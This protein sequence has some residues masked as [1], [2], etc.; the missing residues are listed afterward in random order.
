MH[1]KKF[2]LFLLLISYGFSEDLA[3]LLNE[4]RIESELSKITK[5]ESAG[6]VDI[7][8]RED[9]EKMQARSLLDILKTL[10]V[11]MLTRTSNN[12]YL[13]SK[14]TSSYI[15]MPAIRLFINDHDVTSTSFGS[16]MVVWSDMPVEYIDHIEVYKTAS[17]MEFSNEP[18]TAIIKVYTKKAEREEGG[19][20]RVLK[21]QKG[22]FEADTYFAHT[23][24]DGFSYFFYV[25]TNNI[26]R[27]KYD[28]KE[29]EISSDKKGYNF[30][31]DILYNDW[32]IEL[33][34]YFKENENFMGI[35]TN[36]TPSD[37]KVDVKQSYVHITKNF[38][39]SFKLQLEYD[40]LDYDR[41]YQ[42]ENGI[43]AGSAGIVD[44]YSTH[45]KDDVF[46]VIAEKRLLFEKN[47]LLL[48]AFYKYKG[49]KA[50]GKFD[51]ISTN[52]AN[53]L[54]LYSL[55]AENSFSFDEKTMIVGSIKEDFYIYDKEVRSHSHHIIR[56]GFIKNI[57]N[58]QFKA[59][60]TRT[61]YPVEFYKLYNKDD[62]PYKIN[63]NL[64]FPIIDIH[65]ASIRYKKKG[66]EVEFRASAHRL[67]D[68]VIFSDS[69]F[70]NSPDTVRKEFYLLKYAYLFDRNDRLYLEFFTGENNKGVELSP[71][72][73]IN[74]RIFNS[75]G[76]FDFYNELIYKS[77]Y[78][79]YGISVDKTFDWTAAA[80]YHYSPNLSIG[81]R[82][83]NIF[84][85]S[86]K[87]VY[88]NFPY[89]IPVF[90]K[91]FWINMEYL[92]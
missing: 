18:G 13:F 32:R 55:Y 91:K 51:Q 57:G 48:G 70:I 71:K 34:H 1:L 40:N 52:Y 15:P 31:S 89:A 2:F 85:S 68:N 46:S 79:A 26:K 58:F 17:S 56:L 65:M 81:I 83:E 16:A 22:S 77:S 80:K 33:A 39:N 69:G 19:K 10:P 20:L 72:Y 78:E 21:D 36:Y 88:K 90:D 24:L 45:C 92:F 53:S 75:Y 54:N 47:R 14:P 5:I 35:G 6:F 43:Y 76:K 64:R 8:T 49:F 29:Y 82:G 44:Y 61:Y 74:F 59:F 62:I 42:D 73:G 66:Y 37:G 23:A 67:K 63:P 7:Y 25:N 84:N 28:H 27:K 60:S 38:K 50:E 9:L 30:Y 11:L 41:T 86:F 3:K 87:Q 4:Y 12:L